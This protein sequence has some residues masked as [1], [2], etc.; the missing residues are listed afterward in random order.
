MIANYTAD[1]PPESQWVVDVCKVGYG[2]ACCRYLCPTPDGWS[3]EKASIIGRGIDED[4][5]SG[6]CKRIG[7]NCAGR[8][9][10]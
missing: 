10:R 9:R 6:K 8:G 3:C 4:V 5:A 7:D 1:D 2:P